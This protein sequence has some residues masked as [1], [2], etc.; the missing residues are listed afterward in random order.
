MAEEIVV[1]NFLYA[2]IADF[3][4]MSDILADTESLKISIAF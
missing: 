3:D 2:I 1:N 4:S